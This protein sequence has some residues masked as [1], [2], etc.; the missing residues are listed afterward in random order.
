MKNPYLADLDAFKSNIVFC[1]WNGENEMSER[2]KFGI[3]SIFENI[4]CPVVFITNKTVRDWEVPEYPFHPGF[5]YLSATQKGDYLK[6]YLL[7][8]YGGGYTDIKPTAVS[9]ALMFQMLRDSDKLGLGYTEVGPHGVAPIGGE[10]QR[11]MQEH[12]KEMIGCGAFI[13]KR[14]TEFTE[15]W[16]DTTHA[17][18]DANLVELIKNPAIHPQDHK[19]IWFYNL[20]RESHYPFTW[21]GMCGDIFHPIVYAFRDKL[22]K[23]DPI[24]PDFNNYR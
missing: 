16:L 1:T 5:Q 21:T 12:Y 17:V 10:L 23:Y 2:R 24:A 9:W 13:F 6:T 22:I 15:R 11:V 19:G 18:M 4:G 7:H 14:K 8:H 20:N 3:W